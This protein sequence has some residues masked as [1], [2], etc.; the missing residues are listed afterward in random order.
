ML[1]ASA[2]LINWRAD[3]T[4]G[5][6]RARND[7]N[8]PGGISARRRLDCFWFDCGLHTTEF[9]ETKQH[10]HSC[11]ALRRPGVARRTHVGPMPNRLFR[12]LYL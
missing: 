8:K 1:S 12:V 11:F 10:G 4:G 5:L 3:T 2:W 6:G 9:V 7:Y